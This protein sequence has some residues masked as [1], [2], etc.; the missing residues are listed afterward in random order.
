MDHPYEGFGG[1][2]NGSQHAGLPLAGHGAELLHHA[3]GVE[4]LPVLNQL[5]PDDP[6]YHDGPYTALLAGGGHPQEV[7]PVG[8]RHR[9][10]GSHLL[11][12]GYLVLNPH[13]EAGKGGP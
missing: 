5:S 4:L 3:Q 13:R 2:E 1:A 8:P 9:D 10:P 12:L 6:V 11:A 7:A